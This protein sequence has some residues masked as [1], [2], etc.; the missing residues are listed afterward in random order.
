L[1][2]LGSKTSPSGLQP[3]TPSFNVKRSFSSSSQT[4]QQTVK[5]SKKK[6]KLE[7]TGMSI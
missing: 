3:T 4:P 2:I 6:I 1:V 7:E 5:Q